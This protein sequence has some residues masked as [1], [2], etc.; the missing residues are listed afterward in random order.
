MNTISSRQIANSKYIPLFH[1][2][3]II[4][5]LSKNYD[6]FRFL[7][8]I[9]DVQPNKINYRF[10]LR[11]GISGITYRILGEGELVEG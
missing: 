8:F 1:V 2:L 5:D 11:R 4:L 10:C 7:E 6:Q 3:Q 9:Q